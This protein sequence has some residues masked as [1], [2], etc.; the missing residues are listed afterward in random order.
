MPVAHAKQ[1]FPKMLL[2]RAGK[3]CAVNA[4]LEQS[5]TDITTCRVAWISFVLH[6]VPPV[7]ELGILPCGLFQLEIFFKE[8]FLSDCG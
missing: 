8:L 3:E 5:A 4:L 7:G 6:I 2:D 1:Y